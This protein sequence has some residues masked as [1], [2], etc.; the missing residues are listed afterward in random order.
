MH[1]LQRSASKGSDTAQMESLLRSGMPDAVGSVPRTLLLHTG[2]RPGA[3]LSRQGVSKLDKR[4]F[5]VNLGYCQR[6]S[7]LDFDARAMDLRNLLFFEVSCASRL[8]AE[9]GS[10][11]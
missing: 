4:A 6:G 3:A 11:S 9:Q 5:P 1:P 8:P 10:S 7:P 2:A